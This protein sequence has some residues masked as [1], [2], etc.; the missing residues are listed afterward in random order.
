[1]RPII[2][3]IP[4]KWKWG[5]FVKGEMDVWDFEKSQHMMGGGRV[6]FIITDNIVKSRKANWMVCADME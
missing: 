2:F 4:I 6:H 5:Q 3:M 1:M